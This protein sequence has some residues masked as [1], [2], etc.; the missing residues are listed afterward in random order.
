MAVTG[1]GPVIENYPAA[2]VR[3]V[4]LF[5]DTAR[6]LTSITFRFPLGVKF[7]GANYDGLFV[8]DVDCTPSGLQSPHGYKDIEEQPA[9][10]IYDSVICTTLSKTFDEV[11]AYIAERWPV[12]ISNAYATELLTG[13]V[14]GGHSLQGDDTALGASSTVLGAISTLDAVLAQ[15]LRGGQGM[16]HLAPSLLAYAVTNGSVN[17]RGDTYFSPS[18]HVVVADSAYEPS[19]DPD[20]VTTV[21]A[22]ATG[23]VYWAATD[24]IPLSGIAHENTDFARNTVQAIEESYGLLL[25]DPDL[26]W[27]TV[28]TKA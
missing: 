9:F 24:R 2:P 14:S 10:S 5:L 17:R 1:F 18:G 21:T 20:S 25:F 15:N 6:R 19:G 11:S 26:V 16:L 4:G 22:Y 28:T 13:A 3:P 8:N 12:L 23:P 27:S 7:Q